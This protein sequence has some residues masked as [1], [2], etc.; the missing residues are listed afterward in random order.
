MGAAALLRR[1][2]QG[3]SRLT[4]DLALGRLDAGH[5]GAPRADIGVHEDGAAA[6]GDAPAVDVSVDESR[7]AVQGDVAGDPP[8]VRTNLSLPATEPFKGADVAG[9]PPPV[10]ANRSA[11]AM[12]GAVHEDGATVNREA[13]DDLPSSWGNRSASAMD[14]AVHE[15]GATVN[16]EAADD[17]PSSWE[18]R[19]V[20]VVDGGIRKGGVTVNGDIVVD[21][22]SSWE[23]HRVS[24]VDGGVRKGGVA[25]NGLPSIRGNR[26]VAMADAGVHEGGVTANGDVRMDLPLGFGARGFST[27]D[28]SLDESGGIRTNGDLSVALPMSSGGDEASTLDVRFSEQEVAA[29]GD[30]RVDLPLGWDGWGSIRYSNLNGSVDG[31]VWDLHAGADYLGADG[32]TVYGALISYEPGRVLSD[33]VRL[34]AGHV[35]LGLYGARRLSEKLTLDGALGWGR[36]DN[37]LSLVGTPSSVT[38]SYRS[39][40][41][42][43]RGDVTGDFGWGGDILRIEPKI[44]ILYTEEDLGAFTDNLGGVAPSERLW[45]AR[46]GLGPKL[47]WSRESSTTH[48]QLRVNLDAHNLEASDED[49]EEVSAS[50]ELGRRWQI[51]EQNSID[52]SAGFDGLGSDWFSSSSLGLKFEGRF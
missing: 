46:V 12:D 35:L 38:A 45:L 41:F 33:S 4:S 9:D 14:G 5:G 47:T 24:V 21:L 13:A 51:N 7:A 10:R 18:N 11:S 50:L 40:R 23:N 28:V 31:G 26:G 37:D 43:V 1:H 52:L 27:L 44:G 17:L 20:S 2:A 30:L 8:P 42:T 32:R 29:D 16:R 49:R 34:E 3:F 25:A 22:P 39:E 36:G 6:N 48:V 19:R 15:D